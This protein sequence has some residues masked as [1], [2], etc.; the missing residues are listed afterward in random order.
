MTKVCLCVVPHTHTQFWKQNI[1]IKN[2][3]FD[4]IF[5]EYNFFNFKSL[6][7]MK[8]KQEDSRFNSAQI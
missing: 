2:Q 6:V 8:S 4:I 1:Q 3:T 5:W 7:E